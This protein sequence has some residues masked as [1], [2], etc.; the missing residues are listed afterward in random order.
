ML[1]LG[2]Y[3]LELEIYKTHY[4]YLLLDY[5]LMLL[6]LYIQKLVE[7]V[8]VEVD[9]VIILILLF[10]LHLGVILHLN[11]LLI[12]RFIFHPHQFVDVQTQEH[13]ITTQLLKLMMGLVDILLSITMN[14]Q[15]I[16]HH[17][18]QRLRLHQRLHHAKQQQ[19]NIT[20]ST[21]QLLT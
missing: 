18:H 3:I 6:G 15:N 9:I 5:N 10:L 16:I 11:P 7:E 14:H 13:K 12:L 21:E 20:N 17:Q 19:P 1:L 2:L 8:V 4:Q